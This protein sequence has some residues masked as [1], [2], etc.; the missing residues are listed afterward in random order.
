LNI[1]SK[2]ALLVSAILVTLLLACVF[3]FVQ[4]QFKYLHENA[5]E[6]IIIAVKDT[7][8]GLSNEQIQGLFEPFNQ[9]DSSVSKRFGGTGPGLA[10]CRRIYENM[11]GNI[12][13]ESIVDEGSTFTVTLPTH[14]ITP[15]R[16]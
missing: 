6:D 4:I 12:I 10:I 1:G 5:G 2:I 16:I 3:V 15:D 7:G 8:V 13:V 9:G 11:G 14:I